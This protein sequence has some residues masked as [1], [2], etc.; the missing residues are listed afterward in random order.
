MLHH[1]RPKA[2]LF[3]K[4]NIHTYRPPRH[5]R[6]KQQVDTL[7][8]HQ[9]TQG[10]SHFYHF[11]YHWL[12]NISRNVKTIFPRQIATQFHQLLCQSNCSH[13][14]VLSTHQKPCSLYLLPIISTSTLSHTQSVMNKACIYVL[15]IYK[16]GVERYVNIQ[17][18]IN[19]NVQQAKLCCCDIESFYGY[20]QKLSPL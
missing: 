6:P 20:L 4:R 3:T 12:I 19:E 2:L 5:K 7:Y 17:Q 15:Q 11:K 18:L 10:P 14:A 8:S 1:K 16:L 9:L 13:R